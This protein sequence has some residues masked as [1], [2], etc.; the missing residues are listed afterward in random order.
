MSNTSEDIQ[1]AGFDTLPPILDRTDFE[2][3]QQRIHL[4]C[5]GTDD[6]KNIMKSIVKGP[7]QMGTKRETLARGVEGAL[8]LGPEQDRVFS[9]LIQEEND[10]GLRESNFDQLY[11]YLKQHEIAHKIKRD[12]PPTDD[13]IK[14]LT[15]TLSILTQSYK[16]HLPQINNQL[17]TS[18][19]T[20]NKATVQ[21][22]RVVV[23][24]V[25]G[26]YNARQ[27]KKNNA[28]GF[29]RTRNVEG[30]NKVRN[31]NPGRAKPIKCY[32]CNGIG[33][34]AREC[35]QPK[36][37]QDSDY[38]KDKMLLMQAQENGAVLDEEKLL[39]L[40]GEQVTNFDDDVDDPSEKDLALNVDHAFEADQC[41]AFDSDVD[42][43]P[44]TH[45]MFMV[46]LSSKDPI[47]DEAEPSYDSDIPSEVQDHDNCSDSVYEH[48][49]V[50]EMQNNVQ[51]DYVA[52]SDANYTSDSNTIL[53]DQYVEDN[54]EHVVQRNLSSIQNDALKMII[55]DMHEQEDTLEF[56]VITMKRMLARVKIPLCVEH[57]YKFTPPDYSKNNFLA[58]FTPQ[59]DLTQEQIFWSK[60]VKQR[61][62]VETTVTKPLSALIVEV[63]RAQGVK[64]LESKN[65]ELTEHVY[66]I[67][68]Q[69]EH[70][71]AENEKNLKAQL[72][73]NTK[74]VTVD[75]VK[76]KVFAPVMYAIDVEPIPSRLM[77]NRDAHFDYL[78]H[79]KESVE[80]ELL[81][82]VIGT[83]PKESIKRDN[84]DAIIPLTRIEKVTF[85]D[86]CG[87]STNNT[88]KHVVQ[89]KVHQSN[90]PVIPSTGVSSY[91]KAG[92][93]KPRNNTKKNRIMPAKSENEKKVEDHH[94][95]NKYRWIK[96]NRVDF[97]ISS[98]RNCSKLKK[99][100]K[101]FI[102]IVRFGNDHFGQFCDLDLEVA[103]RKHS[104]FVHDTEGVDLLKASKNKS[105]LWHRRL[106]HLNFGTINNL[107]QR[108]LVKFLRSKDETSEFV[109]KFL[110][111]IQVGLN[112]TVR[113][114]RTDNGKEFFNQFMMEFYKRV[115]IF[116][117]KSILRTPQQNGVV[118]RRN[119][120]FVE[121]VR[122]MLIFSKALMFLEDLGKMQAKADI[123]IFVGYA[124]TRKGITPSQVPTTTYIPPTDKELEILFQPMFDEYFELIR[125]NEPVSS[126]TAI[127]AQVVPPGTSMS[128]TFN[129]D[130][131]S[132]SISPLSS[133]KQTPVLHQ[134]VA[135]GPTIEDTQITQATPHPSVNPFV[136][137]LVLH[138]M[139][140][141]IHEFD[142][143]EVWVL[144]CKLD[145]EMIIALKWIYKVKLDEYGDV[146]QKS[147]VSSKWISS[148]GGLKQAPRAWYDTLSKFLMANKFSK[149]VVDPTLFMQKSGKHILLVQ[150]YVDDII[151]SSTD[152]SACNIF[153][154]E[155]ISKFQMSI[156]GQMLFF[157]GL[158]VSQSPGGIFINQAKYALEIL[159]K[160]GMD[161]S[162]P[163]D[164]PMVDRLKLDE[165]LLGIPNNCMA[166]TAYADA[167]HADCQDSKRSTSGS[168]Q[169]LRDR[170]V[171]WSSKKQISTA[172]STIEAE[173]IA[174]SRC[175][176]QILWIRSRLKDF[177]FGFNKIPLYRDN[178]SAITLCCNNVQHSRS[179]YIDIRHHF[180]REQVENRVV[181]LYFVATEYQLA[182]ILTKALPREPFEFQLP[183]LGMKS[184]TPETLKRLQKRED[185]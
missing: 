89:Q 14:S 11:A 92:G 33:H 57:K 29:F 108:D 132:T 80:T 94:K 67:L 154:E 109:T 165:D 74:C 136:R 2:S 121:A 26:R 147:S 84:K 152:P 98:K 175:C 87:T 63:D 131:P 50:H 93:S 105:W 6:G 56:T 179:K 10:R 168:A 156:M 4:Y 182:D 59:R 66:A 128:R 143:L 140:D 159:K 163:V 91:T 97:S 17:R 113:Y 15:N 90:V 3:W 139:Q 129:Q 101:K 174:M 180:I 39:F 13:L 181:E 78:N 183:R 114:I 75:P 150:I 176:A 16:A 151:F 23:Q 162:D 58:T 86:T 155:M 43:A 81:K 27:F 117:Q 60:E 45:T 146:L 173:Y 148:R 171:S 73:G 18:F 83:C 145:N 42:E 160:Y 54:A 44:T 71:R 120:T 35:P 21:D 22:G 19:N 106:N 9:D 65:L 116:H 38:F 164:T 25:R 30:R 110:T 47:Y 130:A 36:R 125:D 72:K 170:L 37:P 34:I 138:T 82:Y 133:D 7:Y 137:E 12:L 32:N 99:F 100:V 62:R 49:D 185:E 127:N 69:N 177:G 118:E 158:Q 122:K 85:N 1:Y 142:R 20:R 161:L 153:S 144:V 79:L 53:Y 46:N 48:H 102:G 68:E 107:A 70:F 8:Q 64:A 157:F 104:C 76:P 88:Q 172:I 134:G 169:F 103:F 141:E 5:S 126:A 184:M 61:K 115:G 149:G 51:Q 28:R 111:Q 55:D 123:R 96:V 119:R 166:L 24:D 77:N 167:D 40:A 124:T 178:K 112:K 31:L 41:D 52:D 135:S 95:T